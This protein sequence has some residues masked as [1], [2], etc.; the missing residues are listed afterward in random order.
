LKVLLV[1][2]H[3]VVRRGLRQIL[4]EAY[5]RAHFG[6]ASNGQEALHLLASKPWDLVL[7]DVCLP[8]IS[9]LDVLKQIRQHSPRLPVLALS[10][11]PESLY[12]IRILKSGASG[13]ITKQSAPEVLAAAV[14]KVLGGG[15]YV[16][17][18]LAERLAEEVGAGDGR[19]PHELLSNREYEILR[20]LGAGKRLT[21]IAVE[22]G[23]SPKTVGTYR[24]RILEKMRMRTNAQLMRY[25]LDYGLVE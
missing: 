13:Y 21:E 25:A 20:H 19:P 1:D 3:A 4:A 10:Y 8:G 11:Y 9:G 16:S 7:L 17:P 5:P 15:R 23:L 6:E 12:G 2:D 24:A 22:L 18:S 14:R